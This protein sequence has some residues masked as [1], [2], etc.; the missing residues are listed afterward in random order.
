M[1]K[2]KFF[3]INTLLLIASIIVIALTLTTYLNQNKQTSTSQVATSS[4]SKVPQTSTTASSLTWEKQEQVVQIPILMYHAIHVM[5]PSETASAN[6]IV[7]PD[8]F[9]SHIKALVD[10]G[11]YFLTPEEAYKALTEN[12]LPS[13]KVVWITFDDGNADFYTQAY[14]ILK[15]YG[16]K[17]TNHIITGFAQEG[18]TSNLT[19]EQ[20]K[21]M[22]ENGI[23]FQ[24]HTVN[25]PDLSTSDHQ[26]QNTEL[27]DSKTFL[28]QALNQDTIA[29][30][31]PAGRYNQETL[32]LSQNYYQLATTTNEGLASIEDGLLSLDRIRILP[33]T[34]ADN[35]LTTIT[36]K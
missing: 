26:T 27:Q 35:L 33:S 34:T 28:D 25:H 36:S 19:I 5:D 30:A 3:W 32:Q 8:V 24:S 16:V 20:M 17:A 21:E 7:A 31:Y 11:Y 9:E 13:Q 15:K 18:R 2:S 12:S 14:P 29:I 22:K 6:L 23:S 1:L 4:S 10:Q